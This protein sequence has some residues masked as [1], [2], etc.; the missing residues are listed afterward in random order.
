MSSP[1]GVNVKE[2]LG[3]V[4]PS[5]SSLSDN[6]SHDSTESLKEHDYIGLSEVSS[7]MES[8]VLSCQDGEENNLNLKET[9]LRLGLPGSLSPTRDSSS[10]E[11]SLLGP[12]MIRTEVVEEKKLFP[13]EKQQH[14][15]KE[16]VTEDKNGQDKYNIHSSS[17][18]MMSTTPKS[19]MTGAKRGFTEAMEARNCFSDARNNGGFSGEGKWVFPSPAGVVVGGSDVELSKPSPQ[20]K[21]LASAS[22]TPKGPTSWHTGGLD[23][24]GTSS[25]FMASRPSAGA[26]LNLKSVKDGAAPSI[27]VKDIV[28][29]KMPQERPRSEPQHG[30]NQNQ[31]SSANDPGMAPASK[32]QVVGWPPI[33]NFRKNTLAANPK[34][35]DE[36]EGKP[37]SSALYVKVSMDGAP[38]LR[39]VDLKMYA[40]YLELSTAL[41]KMFSCF[42]IGQC[43]SHGVP[44]RDG[45]S[46]SKLMD[47]LH[48][49][50]YV[51]TY[52]DRDG[53]W[54]LVGDVPWEMFVD[55]CKRLRIMKGSEAIGLA[56]RAMEKCKNR[57]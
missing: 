57:N 36:T 28:Q 18:N 46:E 30:A 3:K 8:S 32:A 44:G 50:E 26:N 35:I 7:S 43:G 31:M 56:P 13:M 16:G 41:E 6:N 37:G 11:L 34:T 47:L 55:S 24:S 48:G 33:R 5:V 49:S 52:E 53:D 4:S 17:R 42:T 29:P 45:L 51:L 25:P 2:G 1:V 40:C 12:L 54:M 19:I 14:S 22:G 21:F 10:S 27:G 9:E 39:K 20:G 38:Y 15:G 23:H